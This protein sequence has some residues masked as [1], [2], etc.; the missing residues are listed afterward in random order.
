MSRASLPDAICY[1]FPLECP[2]CAA[3]SGMPYKASTLE[4]AVAVEVRCKDCQHE[5]RC[6]LQSSAAVLTPK[7]DRRKTPRDSASAKKRLT[8]RKS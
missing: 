1:E 8:R 6:L 3:V 2:N 7:R 4:G 5:W